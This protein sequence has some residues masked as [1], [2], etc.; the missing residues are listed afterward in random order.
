MVQIIDLVGPNRAVAIFGVKLVGF[1]AE[2]GKK[3][4]FSLILF[5]ILWLLAKSIRKLV[6][7]HFRGRRDARAAFW[8]NQALNIIFTLIFFIFFVSIWFD[9]PVRLTT[10]VGLITAG[11][12]F[13]LQ[14]LVTSIAGYFIILKGGLFNVGDRISMGGVRGDVIRLGFSH[15]TVLEMGQ[16]PAVQMADPAMWVQARQ[17]T[18]RVVTI[19]NDKVFDT[20]VYNYTREFP[21]LWEEIHVMIPYSAD[22]KKAEQVLLDTAER[23]TIHISKMSAED[24]RE[25]EQRYFIRAAE[26]RPK[27]YYRITDNWLELTIR[28]IVESSRIRELKDKMNRQILEGFENA[29]I[30]VASATIEITNLPPVRLREDREGPQ[31]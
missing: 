24:L 7:W 18:G 9:D 20:P 26:L 19:T 27:V 15:T 2:N 28:F 29:G 17:Y 8:S 1:T 12:A 6:R 23:H 16:P 31:P 5:L 21:Y 3:L 25:F 4:I 14:R 10:A 22:R 13:A 11:L 30:S